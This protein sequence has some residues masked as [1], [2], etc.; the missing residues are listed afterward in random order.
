MYTYGHNVFSFLFNLIRKISS[1]FYW[2][3]FLN[4]FGKAMTLMDR[5]PS[6]RKPITGDSL[7]GLQCHSTSSPGPLLPVC[8]WDM[9]SRLPAPAPCGDVSSQHYKLPF[10]SQK[11]KPLFL[12]L[13]LVTVIY[14]SNRRV[15]HSFAI[16]IFFPTK[17]LIAR[18]SFLS[19]STRYSQETSTRFVFE[20]SEPLD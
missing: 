20:A 6:W 8:S 12:Q 19:F 13:L 3:I 9:I 2:F 16:L 7:W 10:W 1:S 5:R 17:Y 4:F 18:Y 14:H 11:T 15:I